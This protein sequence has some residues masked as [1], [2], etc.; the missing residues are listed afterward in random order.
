[1]LHR[2]LLAAVIGVAL[3]V[4]VVAQPAD[5][6]AFQPTRASIDLYYTWRT[7][8][9]T[10]MTIGLDN[11]TN[12][13]ASV[14]LQPA[15]GTLT[16]TLTS[17]TYRPDPGY[18]G[19]DAFVAQVC[20]AFDCTTFAINVRVEGSPVVLTAASGE[21]IPYDTA[22]GGVWRQPYHGSLTVDTF[23]NAH[24]YTSN[25]GFN[26]LD[27][28]VVTT[29]CPVSSQSVADQCVVE[30]IWVRVGSGP[31]NTG[32]ALPSTGLTSV[33]I[34]WSGLGLCGAGAILLRLA[35]RAGLRADA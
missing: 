21:T 12:Q 3:P 16:V 20:A 35:R 1:M 2:Y 15:H 5:A 8:P 6:A 19:H 25:P 34:V 10:A 31:A 24:S 14:S 30:T 11:P 9:G 33:P 28:F 22:D 4:S 18:S 17:I 26:G 23:T 13:D 27:S 7:P 32:S 29:S